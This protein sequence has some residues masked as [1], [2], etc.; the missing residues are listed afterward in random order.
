MIFPRQKTR[1]DRLDRIKDMHVRNKRRIV[2]T[3]EADFGSRP[4]GQSLVT[5]VLA[6][7]MEVKETRGK[8][9][10]RLR[11]RRLDCAH[12]PSCSLP[13]E[14][15]DTRDEGVLSGWVSLLD[16]CIHRC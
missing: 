1:I 9:R 10:H 14:P 8:I 2:E 6:T 7:N 16:I 11:D 13:E 3:L 12:G 4:Q 15:V 5:D